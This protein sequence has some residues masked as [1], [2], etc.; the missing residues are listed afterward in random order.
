MFCYTY[1]GQLVQPLVAQ[2]NSATAAG[3]VTVY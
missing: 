1:T 3:L 2:L